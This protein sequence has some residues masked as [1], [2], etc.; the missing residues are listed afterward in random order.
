MAPSDQALSGQLSPI[1]QAQL[2]TAALYDRLATP[3]RVHRIE[4][5]MITLAVVGF[6]LH[7]LLVWLCSLLPAL[8][9]L[10]PIVGVNYLGALYTPFSAILFYELLLLVLSIPES[11]TLALG[12]QFEIISLITIRNVFKDLA[13]FESL[14]NL[15][16]QTG[17]LQK[18]LLDMGGGVLLFLMVGVFYHVNRVR[19]PQE[20][21]QPAT[22]ALFIAQKKL[23]ALCLSALFFI[24]LGTSLASWGSAALATLGGEG[25]PPRSLTTIFYTDIFTVLV[26]ADVLLLVLSLRLSDSY[27]LVF[28]N[29]G[30][31]AS[32]IL[33]R[34]SI[35]AAWPYSLLAAIAAVGFGLLINTV[36]KYGSRVTPPA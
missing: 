9:P 22:L 21:M 25:A 15:E 14:S 31:V 19:T 12:R 2:R 27:P 11:T 29:A 16:A 33:L 7:L 17:I 36:Y 24:L 13:E 5:L 32:T 30:F 28:R 18:V 35:G 8:A 4:R 1:D 10:R 3:A 20:Q 26:F 23:V 34:I 6:M